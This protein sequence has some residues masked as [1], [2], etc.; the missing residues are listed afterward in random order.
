MTGQRDPG[1][2]AGD[3]V[4]AARLLRGVSQ[5]S[6]AKSLGL[7]QGA[8][9]QIESGRMSPSSEQIDAIADVTN[10]PISFF[11]AVPP[12]LPPITLRFR[13]QSRASASDTN[14]ATQLIA[15][16]YRIVWTLVHERDGYLPPSL[17]LATDQVLTDDEIERFAAATRTTLGLDESS[18]IRHITRAL[19]RGGIVV[20]PLSLSD[21]EDHAE[22]VGHFGA[23]C[24]PG[25]GDPALIGYFHGAAGDRQRFTLAHEVG[26]LVLHSRRT[27]VADPEG[28]ANR[29]AGSILVPPMA[30][31][32]F[33]GNAAPTLRDFARM[34]AK[35][36]VSI[37]GLI[38]RGSH[39]GLIDESRKTSLF[40]QISARGYRKNEPVTVRPEEPMLFAKLIES[41][42]G[43]AKN[44]YMTAA[45]KVGLDSFMLAGLAPRRAGS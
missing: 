12:D 21:E 5:T 35:W 40:K 9:S 42:Y 37:Q 10:L 44:V 17:P 3:R 43:S 18:P 7:T 14:R 23:S 38:M 19:E 20:A 24:W 33:V 28:E 41:R 16:A 39:L 11:D 32:E 36:G 26:H 22:T 4:R 30:Y 8:I 6:L 27:F 45:P 15:E 34:K 2:F 13:K 25:P 1:I 31:E 29:F